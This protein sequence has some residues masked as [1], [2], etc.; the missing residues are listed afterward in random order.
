MY[1]RA[2][3]RLW[4]PISSDATLRIAVL[5]S[6]SNDPLVLLIPLIAAVIGW[7]TNVVAVQ[8]MFYPLRFIGI[9]PWLGWQGII[10]ANAMEMSRISTE[11][12]TS[13][14]LNLKILFEDFDASSFSGNLG[15][16]MD[17]ITEEIIE[18]VAARLG[19]DQWRD[20]PEPMKDQVR[21]MFRVEVEAVTVK[22][23]ADMGDSIETIIDLKAIVLGAVEKNKALI[24]DMFQTVG[25]EEFRFIKRSGAYFG[26]VFG[27][28]QLLAWLVYPAWWVLPAFG[29]FVGYVTNWLA[30]K[31]IFKPAEPKKIGP[32]T[33]QG[34]F[35]KRQ[36]QVADAFA[37]MVSDEILNADNIVRYMTTGAAGERLFSI[38]EARIG[39][40]LD[41]YRKNPM[42]SA[43]VKG[44]E[45]DQIRGELSARIRER[46]PEKGGFLYTFT[47]RAVNVYS[48]L[49][50]RMRELDSESF[51]GVLRP[52]FQKD[53]WKL[54]V[55]GAALG[56]GAGIL[57]VVYLFG[58]SL[59]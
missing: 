55:A 33:I 26:F 42:V 21:Q 18:Q 31:L 36:H 38:V 20:L 2:A 43:M 34:L 25:D 11:I 13:Q 59:L 44:D 5:Q 48:E 41:G 10:P 19:D 12:I 22:I 32:V 50:G 40:L 16:A 17:E 46:L 54:I 47:E 29:F 39:E 1:N 3:A 27:I 24:G 9:P 57:Q 28:V 49:F 45:W 35:H 6:I 52:A 51:E 8:M 30:I 7:G 56:L 58:D 23:L 37:K 4:P 14:L 15:G 53:E